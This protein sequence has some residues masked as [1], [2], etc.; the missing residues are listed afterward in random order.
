[1]RLGQGLFVR[2]A[3]L[4]FSCSNVAADSSVRIT[5]GRARAALEFGRT[6]SQTFRSMLD[7]IDQTDVLVHV[8]EG[9]CP[10]SRTLACTTYVATTPTKRYLRIT[11]VRFLPPRAIVVLLAHELQHVIELASDSHVRD[12]VG[13]SEFYATRGW[14]SGSK[15]FESREASYMSA[16]VEHEISTARF[17]KR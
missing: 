1:M 4:A 3:I 11:I 8:V 7:R 17:E 16:R 2:A 14:Q 15:A 9:A 6:N 5:F 10:D 13:V 12:S